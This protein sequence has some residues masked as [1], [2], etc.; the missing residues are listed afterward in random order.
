[1]KDK[2]L[3]FSSTNYAMPYLKGKVVGK[4]KPLESQ[5]SCSKYPHQDVAFV[6]GAI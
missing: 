4:D 6:I 3:K 2:E 5:V 1:M